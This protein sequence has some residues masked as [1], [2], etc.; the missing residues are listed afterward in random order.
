MMIPFSSVLA[1]GS[2]LVS[3]CMCDRPCLESPQS[4]DCFFWIVILT[5]LIHFALSTEVHPN[6]LQHACFRGEP[7][8]DIG[9]NSLF[10]LIIVVVA[11]SLFCLILIVVANFLFWLILGVLAKSLFYLIIVV[12]ANSL[13]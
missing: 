13:F 8:L 10:C 11:S 12:V 6:R 7:Y 9:A 1:F 2:T 4:F 3:N 5:L